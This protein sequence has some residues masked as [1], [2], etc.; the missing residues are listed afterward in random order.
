MKHYLLEV[1][2]CLP[3]ENDAQNKSNFEAIFVND[4]CF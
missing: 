4:V 3:F 2:Y 1:T